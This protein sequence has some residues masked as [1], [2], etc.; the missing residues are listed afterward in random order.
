MVQTVIGINSAMMQMPDILWHGTGEKYVVSIDAQGLLPKSRLYVHLSSDKETAR[1]V[2]SRHGRPVIY[3]IDCQQMSADG[4]RF[5]ESAN[6]VW[7]TKEVPV[8]YL[9]K[10]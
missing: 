7:L 4:Y 8:R 10:L 6:H 3:E 9:R 2:G 1:K 5:F